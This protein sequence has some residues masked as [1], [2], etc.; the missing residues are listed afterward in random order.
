MYRLL[1][2]NYKLL[3]ALGS[4]IWA[5]TPNVIFHLNKNNVSKDITDSFKKLYLKNPL[6]YSDIDRL[7]KEQQATDL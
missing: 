2:E 3:E 5:K 4:Y 6:I 1:E 7:F